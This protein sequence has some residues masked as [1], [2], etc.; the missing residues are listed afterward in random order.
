MFRQLQIPTLILIGV[1]ASIS[2]ANTPRTILFLGDSLTAGY[3]LDPSLAYPSLIQERIDAS[4]LN[5]R[6]LNGGLSGETTAGGLRRI[7]WMLRR[8]VGVIVIALGANDGLRGLN[9]ENSQQNLQ[10]IIDTTHKNSP[11][12]RFLIAG[13]RVPPNM[14]SE[15]SAAFERI[16]SDLAEKNSIPMI[17]FLLEDV[18]THS[19]LNLPDGI[20]PNEEGHKII[21]KTVWKYLLPILQ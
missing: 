5:Y 4:G 20:H 2:A 19:E 12:T 13:M 1:V 14:G 15:Y 11:H 9:P 7:Q 6:I 18:A 21:A 17:P 10:S 3:G 8:P 16:F